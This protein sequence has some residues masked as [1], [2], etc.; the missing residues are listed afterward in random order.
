MDIPFYASASNCMRVPVPLPSVILKS[1]LL[2][3]TSEWFV[4]LFL[5]SI[6]SFCL[7]IMFSCL[8]TCLVI[9]YI[10]YRWYRDFRWCDFPNK[11]FLLSSFKQ[12]GV[13]DDNL[14]SVKNWAGLGLSFSF[15][16]TI[17]PWFPPIPHV[18][19]LIRNLQVSL[20]SAMKDCGGSALLFR[21]SQSSFPG[22]VSLEI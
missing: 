21:G 22:S 8:F 19:I 7:S 12:M 15:Y 10:V 18:W 9:F 5:L 11:V 6:F 3:P 16:K 20:S 2:T 14:S 1:C 17:H 13:R 4:Y